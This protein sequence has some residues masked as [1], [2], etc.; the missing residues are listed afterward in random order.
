MYILICVYICILINRKSF[1]YPQLAHGCLL[2]TESLLLAVSSTDAHKT[3]HSH[4]KMN[5]F[6]Y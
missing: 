2:R 1:Q 6:T 5:R 3:N 4:G